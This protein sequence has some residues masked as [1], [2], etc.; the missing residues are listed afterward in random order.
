[1]VE[2]GGGWCSL[3]G[4]R[5]ILLV[6]S[7]FITMLGIFRSYNQIHL[8]STFNRLCIDGTI[9]GSLTK[10]NLIFHRD[11][12][13]I[14]TFSW[15]IFMNNSEDYNTSNSYH[16]LGNNRHDIGRGFWT[17]VHISK[18]VHLSFDSGWLLQENHL[19]YD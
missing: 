19:N 18:L 15:H 6:S 17:N 5:A 10:L 1:M 8:T 9:M 16:S 12:W 2:G 3:R 14:L 11:Y 7:S 13:N 4:C